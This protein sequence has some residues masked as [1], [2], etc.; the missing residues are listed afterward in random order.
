M[1][2]IFVISILFGEIILDFKCRFFC[3]FVFAAGDFVR[4]VKLAPPRWNFELFII[5]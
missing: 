4:S 5:P 3:F 2:K 1:V